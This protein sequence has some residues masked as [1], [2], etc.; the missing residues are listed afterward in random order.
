MNYYELRVQFT[1]FSSWNDIIVAYLAEL[2]FE[3]F[4]EEA[5]VV[6]A[7]I[8]APDFDAV[9]IQQ[10]M[11]Q[12][13]AEAQVV[14]SYD[15]QLMPQQNWNAE[16]ESQFEPVV[17]DERLRIVAPFHQL[18]ATTG[19]EIVIEPKMSFGT[20]HHQTTHLICKTM[21][22]LSLTGKT[23][24]DMGSGTGVLAILAEQLGAASVVAIDIEEWS[25]ENI[26]ENAQRNQCSRIQA[27][28]GGE[29]TIP[30]TRFDCI[31]AN[32]N[33]NVLLAQLPRYAAVAKTAAD[34]LLS[35]FFVADVP[36]LIVAAEAVGFTFKQQHALENWAVLHFLKK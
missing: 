19:L 14:A 17:I 5:P 30:N 22:D 23:I 24:L 35:G 10:L 11:K 26:V 31:L 1:D 9:A 15:L 3:S 28:F 20:G 12:L 32:I 25:A 29:E 21:F 7:Y 27:I 34:L 18:P 36:E 33:K 2:N 16:W 6:C 8:P 4:Q 13:N